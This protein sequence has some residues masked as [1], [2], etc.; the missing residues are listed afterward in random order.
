MKYVAML[1]GMWLVYRSSFQKHLISV[2]GFS[3]NHA[4]AATRKKGE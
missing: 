1:Q 2:L 4:T 3:T